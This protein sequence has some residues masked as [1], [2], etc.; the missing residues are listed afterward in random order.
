MYPSSVIPLTTYDDTS[1]AQAITRR[2]A[3]VP[4][5]RIRLPTASRVHP[6]SADLRRAAAMSSEPAG[7]GSE[8]QR[9]IASAIGVSE[10][11]PC[12]ET[13][14]AQTKISVAVRREEFVIQG[15]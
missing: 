2:G 5:R 7:A 8:I 1:S 12:A 14:A 15:T 13:E 9:E 6:G 4:T 3:P 11:F 10:G